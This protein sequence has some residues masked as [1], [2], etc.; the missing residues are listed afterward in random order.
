MLVLCAAQD[1]RVPS[2][3]VPL[4]GPLPSGQDIAVAQ[5]PTTNERGGF[6]FVV[7]FSDGSKAVWGSLDRTPPRLLVRE[8]DLPPGYRIERAALGANSV[9]YYGR[10]VSGLFPPCDRGVIERDG[11]GLL[12]LSRDMLPVQGSTLT[13][14][15]ALGVPGV[16]PG[17][18]IFGYGTPVEPTLARFGIFD[19]GD[20]SPRLL[21]GD[22]I[23]GATGAITNVLSLKLSPTGAHYG[24]RVVLDSGTADYAVVDGEVL[25]NQGVNVQS[26]MPVHP[27]A[28]AGG[29]TWFRILEVMK[30]ASGDWWVYGGDNPATPNRPF[31]MKNGE[32]IL[33]RGDVVEGRVI[34]RVQG[35]LAVTEGGTA[36][37]LV[38]LEPGT[39]L[40]N[41]VWYEGRLA[42]WP[43]QAVDVDG[44]G[45]P[46]PDRTITSV[47]GFPL[48]DE[49][50]VVWSRVQVTN[51]TQPFLFVKVAMPFGDP[52][53]R[54]A[55]NSTGTSVVAEALGT[56]LIDQ[57][58][59]TLTA[60]GLPGNATGLWL[61]STQPGR[62]PNPAGSAGDLCL[63]GAVGRFAGAIGTASATGELGL[64]VDLTNLPQP[65]GR[66]SA[67]PGETW[68]FQLWYRDTDPQGGASSNFSSTIGIHAR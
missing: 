65:S 34:S 54:G 37:C 63:G 36:A 53:C 8:S 48:V 1:A 14:I 3:V 41:A 43:G 25:Q 42:L 5:F 45:V 16:G 66:V 60:R 51:P 17:R 27:G 67:Q 6:A 58:D 64:S 11:A 68:N 20:P 12:C 21:V 26:G 22:S 24:C 23:F 7:R 10:A 31:L 9:T 50:H 47:D 52:V 46:E 49:D 30:A 38:A 40:D 33:E 13:G 56:Q 35:G 2:V 19:E 59:L 61:T 4:F 44:D 15:E 62:F 57:N 55:T 28:P 32:I 29:P 39:F 18:F